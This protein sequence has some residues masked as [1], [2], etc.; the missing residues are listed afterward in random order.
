[1]KAKKKWPPCIL[2]VS[3]LEIF[4]S[5][6][7]TQPLQFFDD[8]WQNKYHISSFKGLPPINATFGKGKWNKYCP[9]INTAP[10]K[11]R[12]LKCSNVV[13]IRKFAWKRQCLLEERFKRSHFTSL[14]HC[15]TLHSLRNILLFWTDTWFHFLLFL[16]LLN[17]CYPLINT[18]PKCPKIKQMRWRLK[19]EI[20]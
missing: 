11:C 16:D 5:I 2:I 14:V 13:F 7:F 1:M 9:L 17:K 6:L 12:I 18:T 4:V 15:F 19:E 20:W 10:N 3:L 8:W